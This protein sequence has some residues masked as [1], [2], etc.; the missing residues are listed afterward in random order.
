MSLLTIFATATAM[1]G[2]PPNL[3]EA[4]CY[5]ESKHNTEAI[6]FNDGK[7][8]SYGICQIKLSTARQMGF[9]GP[10]YKLLEPQTNIFY[11]AKYLSRQM[12]RYNGNIQK[13]TSAYN[14]GSAVGETKYSK[15]VLKKQKELHE[16]QVKY[17]GAWNIRN[18]CTNLIYNRKLSPSL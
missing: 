2:L 3:L 4:L 7:G 18:L 9:K 15:R 16:A 14:R 1:H 5:E 6:S 8:H 10:I 13:A 17:N 11:A 12:T